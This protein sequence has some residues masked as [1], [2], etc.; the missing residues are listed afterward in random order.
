MVRAVCTAPRQLAFEEIP[1]PEPG[2]EEVLV[3]TVLSGVSVGTE[4]AVYLGKIS[5][6]STGRWGYWNGYPIPVGYELV[7]LA[8]KVG[9]EIRDVREGDRIVGLAPHGTWGLLNPHRFTPIPEGVSD[10]EATMTVLG[11]TTTHGIR[12][13]GIQYGEKV[14]VLGLGVVGLL[15][16]L[17]ARRAGTSDVVVADPLAAKRNLAEE[18]GFGTALD[19]LGQDFEQRIAERT[20][21]MGV[22]AVIEASG[23]PSAI[24]PALQAAR[25]GG[26]ILILGNHT[27]P[28][29]I[30]FSD[31]VMHKEL[32]IIGTWRIGNI[33]PV[34]QQ[35]NRWNDRANLD[36]VMDLI[37]R[38]E[39][40]VRRFI[41]HRF[42][43]R[44]LPD[45]L[46]SIEG[47][48]LAP[49]QL[50]LRY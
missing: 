22:D 1:T 33:L 50:I 28:V 12:R 2:P 19:P 40:P 4:M 42:P 3:K 31:Y 11:A 20:R 27:A 49:I 34:D 24:P 41:T 46:A 47:G 8:A 48:K 35:H 18:L 17:H 36:Y 26:R 9:K 45:V 15:A 44:E 38:G 21:G 5:N 6:L 43:F 30:L 13:A 39:M 37:R 25:R 16:A 10:E 23:H 7:G 32:T 14:L 29:Q